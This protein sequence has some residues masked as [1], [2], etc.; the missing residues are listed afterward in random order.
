MPAACWSA[1]GGGGGGG[2]P[3]GPDGQSASRTRA[4]PCATTK[5]ASCRP[6]PWRAA[7]P[8]W[9]SAGRRGPRGMAEPAGHDRVRTAEPPGRYGA[10]EGTP[11]QSVVRAR[12][13]GNMAIEIRNAREHNL[14]N[15]SV[16]IPHDKFTVITGRVGLGQVHAGLRHPVQRGPAPLPGVA[17][18]LARAIVQPAGQAG[19]RTPSSAF[20]PP[21]PSN[22]APAAA[23][24]SPRWPP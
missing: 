13:Q 7:W 18:R 6:T 1:W 20:R 14:K 5:S 23:A 8:T 4:P 21:W 17:E 15:I 16:E 11:L 9:R 10:G 12:R 19:R 24:A 3:A 2:T 22:S